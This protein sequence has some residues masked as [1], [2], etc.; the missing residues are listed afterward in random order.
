MNDELRAA[1]DRYPNLDVVDWDA[2]VA[3]HPEFVYAD[4]LHLTPPGR[5]AFATAVQQRVAA[6][7]ES[8]SRPGAAAT[9]TA[10]TAATASGVSVAG[11]TADVR[12]EAG[13][14]AG[15]ASSVFGF[16]QTVGGAL[17]GTYTGL[18][19]DGT[20]AP[21]SLGFLTV[22]LLTLGGILAAEKG[23]L[24]GVGEKYQESIAP[25]FSE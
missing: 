1:A 23:K 25:M 11:A 6:Y 17:I 24:F 16:M 5:A 12:A 8:L 13:A 10:E 15:T 2:Q 9:P 3:A 18:A 21:V 19:F 14:V 20:V 4:G 7:R 22:G